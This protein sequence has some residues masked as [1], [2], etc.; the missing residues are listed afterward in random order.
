MCIIG[1][2]VD[3]G[4]GDDV[5]SGGSFC[6]LFFKY[7]CVCIDEWREEGSIWRGCIQSFF[8]S[9]SKSIV[10]G[11]PLSRLSPALRSRVLDV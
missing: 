1:W 4:C 2:C 9:T 6:V 3:G 5:G 11:C 10:E 8:V 7:M